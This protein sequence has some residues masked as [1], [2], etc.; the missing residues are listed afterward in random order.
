MKPVDRKS[1]GHVVVGPISLMVTVVA[2]LALAA[3]LPARGAVACARTLTADVIVFDQPLMYN[4]LGAQNVNGIMYALRRDV[5]ELSC[6]PDP[7]TGAVSCTPGR[8]LAAGGAALAGKVA[9]RPDKRPRPL[10]LRVAAGDCLQVSFANLLAP[11]ANTTNPPAGFALPPVNDQVTSRMAGF[12]AQGMQL[13]TGIGDDASAVGANG[14]SLVAPGGSARYTFF[15]EKEGTF[16][17]TSFGATFGSD[18]SAGNSANGMFA[19][20]NVEPAGARFYRSQVTE[21][22]MRLAS[23]GRTADGQPVLDY[24]ATYPA[25]PGTGVPGAA[26][27]AA[28]AAGATFVP[29]GQ[30]PTT[31]AA[32][33]PATGRA[34]LV[35]PAA[36]TT[37]AA[38]TFSYAIDPASPSGFTLSGTGTPSAVTAADVTPA[39]T[40]I[41]ISQDAAQRTAPFPAD[42]YVTLPGATFHYTLGAADPAT[43]LLDPGVVPPASWPAGTALQFTDATGLPVTVPLALA[44]AWPAGA[45]VQAVDAN[46]ALLSVAVPNVWA[47]EGK[48]GL[49]VLNMLKGAELV[50]SDLNAVITGGGPSGKFDPSTYPLESVG[51]VN[52]S[53]PTRLEPF[54]EYTVVFHDEM[55]VSNAFPLWYAPTVNGVANP[56]AHTLHAVGDVFQVNYG[57]GGVGS[58]VIANRLGVGPMHDCLD[59]VYEEFFLTSSAVGDP[60]MLVDIPANFGLEACAP[61]GANCPATAMG[62]KATRAYYPDDPSNVHH[63]YISDFV[64]FR[65]VHTGKE[66]HIFHLHNHQW[67]FNPNDDNSNYL[68]AQGIGPG[69]GYTYEINFGG[70]GNRNKS[71]GD[72]IFHCH[73]YPHFAQG[74]WELWRIHDVLETGTPLDVSAGGFHATPFGLRDGT[75]AVDPAGGRARALPDGEIVAGTPIPAVVPLPGRPMAVMPGK[76]TV[77]PKVSKGITVGSNAKVARPRNATTCDS[78]DPAAAC[79]DPANVHATLNPKGIRNPGFPFWIAG[80]ESIVGQRMPTPPLDMAGSAG[81]WDG[82]LPRHALDG[83]AASGCPT[84]ATRGACSVSKQSHLDMTKEVHLAAPV[85]FPEDGTDLEKA[86]MA[87]HA[88]REH[89]STTVLLDGSTTAGAFVTNGSG[90]P[91]PGAP[92]HDPC[93]DDRGRLLSAGVTGQ[94]FDGLGGT[95]ITGSSPFNADTP[96]VYKGANIQFDVV[97]NKLG[98]HF[99]QERILT[100]WED[101]VPTIQKKRAPEPMVLRMNTFDCVMYQHTNLV[102]AIYELDDYQVRTTT[103]IIGQHIHLPKWDL[104]TTDGSANGWN[105]ED[106]TLSPDAVRERIHAINAFNPSGAGNPTDSANRPPNT[107]LAAAKHPF[108]PAASPGGLDWTGARTTL[109]RWFS[110][111]V[112]N[113]DG[114]HRGLGIIFTHDHYGPSTHQQVGLYATVLTEPPGSTWVHNETGVPF[115]TRPDGGPT[116]W[117]AA[118]LAGPDSY[119]EFYFEYSDFQHAY[120][121][122]V[123][124]G[125]DQWGGLGA[126]PDA[127]S[128]R[129]AVNPSVKKMHSTP[130]PDLLTFPSVCPSGLPRPCPEGISADDPGF[131]VVNYRNEPVGFRVYDPAKLGPDGK[132]G[133]Q[134][135]GLGGDLAFALQSRTDRKIARLNVQPTP[136]A[137][138]AINGTQ[139]PPALNAGGV[140]AGDPFTPLLRAYFGD[141][142]RIKM[143]AGGHEES[144]SASINGMKWLQG[145]SGYGFAPNSGWRNSQHA[146]ISEQFTFASPTI[147]VL[148]GGV[149]A[150]HLYSLNPSMDGYWSGVWGL[151]RNYGTAQPTLKQLPNGATLPFKLTNAASFTGICPTTAVLRSYDLTAVL[152]NDVLPNVE[153]V[154]IVPTDGSERMNVGGKNAAG[155]SALNPNGGTLVY[156]PRSTTLENGRSGPLH[157]PTAMLWVRTAD[158]VARNPTAKACLDAKK[159]LD[160]TLP[161][162]PVMLKPGAAVEPIVLRAAAGECLGVKVRNRLPAAVPDLATYK[163]LPGIVPRD[164]ADPAGTTTFNNNLIRPSSYVGLHPALVAYDVNI[165]D[166]MAIGATGVASNASGLIAGPGQ[167]QFYRWYAGDISLVPAA[168]GA[169]TA[170]ATPVEFGGAN[171]SPADVIKQGPKGLVGALVIEPAGTTWAETDT[172]RDH[173]TA[174]AAATPRATRVSATLNPGTPLPTRDFVNVIQKGLG[175][176][177]RDGTPVEMIAAE[178]NIAEDAEDSGHMAINYRA[179]PLWFRFGLR[180]NAPL[181][182]GAA[183]EGVGTP[184]SEVARADLAF[185]NQ[186]TGGSDP[187]APIFTASAGAPVRMHLL[188]P[189]GSPRASTFTLHGHI[190]QRAPYVC[191]G[192]AKDGL[193]GKCKATGY[194]PTLAGEVSSR[195]IGWN[196]IGDYTGAQDLMMPGS[197]WDIVL[198]SAGGANGIPGDYLLMDR[199]GFGTTSGLWSLLRVR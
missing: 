12:H 199:A 132:R 124:V 198:P 50:H 25:A 178:G 99:P 131:L 145:G 177:Y 9:L 56:L 94:F 192:S 149:R 160:P 159:K 65:N 117:Q 170:V 197:H 11:A 74:M 168:G 113:V 181:V 173:Q 61:S 102:P 188:L 179:E 162:C 153:G 41:G 106:G 110:D 116:S 10:V 86:A 35:P 83:Y 46:G 195:A 29:V 97:L 80:V 133:S 180:P 68:D 84:G 135:D 119:R 21:E 186:L 20:I 171:L 165:D 144:H 71:A 125:R 52:P 55:A 76:V 157:D 43:L 130:F 88:R 28:A 146:G 40:G 155:S 44:Q 19:V 91:V 23:T 139:F 148:N 13:V 166:G 57:S 163:H 142:V 14:S 38:E 128:F 172:V 93:V 79:T 114:Q 189:T 2:G 66:H 63:S 108:F 105:Y 109:Q 89:A 169:Y 69:G 87:F 138:G 78:G 187:V 3:P 101:A 140:T 129:R 58:E 59:C 141:P 37:L 194:F 107:P 16:L 143:Q 174:S 193:A 137:A 103:D 123:Y 95:G 100:L 185:S 67:L 158:L 118:I 90:R 182:G 54:R 27:T 70:S 7:V 6:R 72:A 39:S 161:A 156:N 92:F 18:G 126:A 115:Y 34:R 33:F 191:P 104:T 47:R 51:K 150:D 127:N 1:G 196:P 4:R 96:R 175:L 85:W 42:G 122:G 30:D 8:P 53:I 176:R 60:A 5:V 154:T 183:G 36:S 82:G 48:A 81:G 31:L 112:V 120:E 22:E 111:P 45:T 26:P 152:A 77:V 121:P 167:T 151:F 134:A 75:P 136:G 24:E 164:Q 73:F 17:V 147:P 64:K 49:P 184:F 190:W 15:A 62:P 32:A 98:Y